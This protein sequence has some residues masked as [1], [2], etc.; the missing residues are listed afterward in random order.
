MERIE[1]KLKR[2]CL[3]LLQFYSYYGGA[4][5]GVDINGDANDDLLV[6]APYYNQTGGDDGIVYL[7]I[8]SGSVNT[9]GI[10]LA[11]VFSFE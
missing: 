8:N 5:C 9:V 11:K 6:G 10:W 2:V 7:Y 1:S 4:L 3:F